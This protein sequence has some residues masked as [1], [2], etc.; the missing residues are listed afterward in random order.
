MQAAKNRPADTP[1]GEHS[2]GWLLVPVAPN[3]C[4]QLPAWQWPVCHMPAIRIF[5][6]MQDCSTGFTSLAMVWHL[7]VRMF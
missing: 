7:L 5:R 6:C 2:K 3:H 4:F 1:R